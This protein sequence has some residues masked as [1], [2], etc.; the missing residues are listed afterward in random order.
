[1]RVLCATTAGEGHFGPLRAVALAC[2][3]A[4]HDV[5]VAAPGSFA[6]AVSR[7]GLPHLPFPDV[8][9]EVMGPLFA[10]L[11]DLPL[12]EANLRVMGEVYA[13]LA[14]QRA[15]P[16]IR[17][18]MEEWRPDVVLREPTEFGSL[19][20]AEAAGLPH[21]EVAIGV[22]G[23]MEWA[24]DALV[25]PLAELDAL[26]GL[27]RGRVLSAAFGSPVFTMVPPSME[28]AASDGRGPGPTGRTVIRFRVADAVRRHGRLPD[29]WGDQG[30]PLVYVTFG[31]V[32]AGL[33][34]MKQVFGAALDALADLP[35]RVLL[36]TGHA[37][38]VELPD[39]P[40]NAHV[41]T[42][43][44]QADVMPS[45]A[46]VVGHGGF[47]TTLGALSAGVPQVVLPL[48]TP[49]QHLNAER[50]A[51][52][53]VGLRVDGGPDGAGLLGSSVARVLAEPSFAQR[54]RVVADEVASLPEVAVVVSQIER[55]GAGRGA[56]GHVEG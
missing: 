36:T 53:G 49:D 18:T 11:P 38:G 14:A 51:A 12:D 24:R 19:A 9:H 37:G 23:L 25:E 33:G 35:V 32:V 4:G 47:G 10:S 56:G 5:R 42:Y 31:T 29:A 22:S 8:P 27:P 28:A 21:A 30:D 48:F 3:A 20:A 41:E 43:W 2:R 15:F 13:R 16:L 44:P 52:L 45:A 50:V 7:A 54:A 55:L 39:V 6:A 17:D 40:S 1:M 26:A 46:V 34:P